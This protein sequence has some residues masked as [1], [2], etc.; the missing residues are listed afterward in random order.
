MVDHLKKRFIGGVGA[1]HVKLSRS[2][3][4]ALNA[5]LPYVRFWH[6]RRNQDNRFEDL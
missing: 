3:L 6:L 2:R 1:R 5:V 4:E